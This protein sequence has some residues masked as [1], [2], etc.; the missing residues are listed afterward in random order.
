MTEKCLSASFVEKKQTYFSKQKNKYLFYT[1]FIFTCYH[2]K[3]R[4][5]FLFVR[6]GVQ[7]KYLILFLL[8]CINY[9]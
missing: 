4:S 1:T 8:L 5:L 9:F 7:N 3:N 6:I 2:I